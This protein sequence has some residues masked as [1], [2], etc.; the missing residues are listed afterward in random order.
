MTEVKIGF[1]QTESAEI[2]EKWE[3]ARLGDVVEELKNGFASGKRDENGIVQIRMNNVTTDGRLI[4]NSYLKVPVPE[5]LNYWLLKKGDLLFNNTNS[6]DLVGKSTIFNDAPFPC[7]FSNHFT[8]I[9][10]KKELVLP[11]LILYHFLILW[12]KNY[13]KS[14][15]IRHVGQS[16]V[17]TE[18]L[19]KLQIPLPP[20]P[21]QR[22]IAEVLGTVDSAIQK[23]GGAIESTE[24]LKKGLMQRLLTRGIG[25]ER[26]KESEVGRVPEMWEVVRLGDVIEELKNGFASGKRDENGIVQIRMN[27]VTTDGRLIFNSY[28]K[29]PVPENINNWLL[30]KGDFLFNNTNSIDLVGKSTIFNDAPFSCTFSNHF[31]RLRFKKDRVSPELILYHFLMLWEK[32]YF[33]SVAI[34]HVGQSAVHTEYLLKLQIPLP[35]LAEQRRIAEIL[36]AVDRKLELERRRK[37]KLERVKK[38]LMNELLTGR[39]RVKVD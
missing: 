21:E 9:R 8:R 16:A 17:H 32:N 29:V 31:T 30:R 5:N 24:R 2:P 1:K 18:Y 37:E 39:K 13:F 12:G 23:V 10:F 7:T 28:L 27:N 26:F 14:V 25:H 4:F 35:P 11:E 15:A 33:K 22:R 38:G 19:L 6:I 36:S 20:L 3:M 34:R